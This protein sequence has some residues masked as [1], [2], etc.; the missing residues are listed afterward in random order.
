MAEPTVQFVEANGLRHAYVEEGQGP[1]VLM[2]H[3]FPDTAETWDE[4]RPAVAA[5]GFR[6]VT[7]HLRG[8]A[9]SG[10]P[11]HDTDARTQGEDVLAL[12]TALG[13]ERAHVVGHDWGASLVF[14]ASALGP[15]K[16]ISLVAMGIPHPAAIVPTPG[17]LWGIRH[18]VSYK[19]PGAVERFARD[20]F[21]EV[22]VLCKRW[23]PTWDFGPE[24]MAA[25]KEAFGQPG[26]L[27]AALGYYRAAPLLVPGWLKTRLAMPTMVFAGRDDPIIRPEAFERGS[28]LADAGYEVVTVP[29]G[30]FLHRESP[31]AVI[32]N[33]IR[34][35]KST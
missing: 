21:A 14:S 12:I 18:F 32:D 25:I 15:E 29:G 17:I 31:A 10:I 7:P 3:G 19:M 9:P 5:A 23:S 22:D 1:L 2:F 4:I 30:H 13:A 20:D 35:L 28:K 16:L 11:D 6:V 24:D 33:L 8:Y 27:N 34:F 26:C